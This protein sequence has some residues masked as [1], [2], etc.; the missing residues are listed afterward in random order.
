MAEKA[1]LTPDR[2]MVD[3]GRAAGVLILGLLESQP[4]AGT[5]KLS[6]LSRGERGD[7]E[8]QF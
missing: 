3:P 4:G 8:I 2:L 1:C 6:G 5:S 7:F